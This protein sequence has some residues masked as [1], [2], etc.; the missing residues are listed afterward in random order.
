MKAADKSGA[1]YCVV[2]GEN[3]ISSGKFEIK[4]MK[5]GTVKEVTMSTLIDFLAE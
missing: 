3:E 1:Q 4:E 2:L 5:T